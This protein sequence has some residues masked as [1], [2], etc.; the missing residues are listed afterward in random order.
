MLNVKISTEIINNNYF[1]EVKILNK[2]VH[3][4]ISRGVD[5]HTAQSLF[6][7]EEFSIEELQKN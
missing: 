5:S 4:L 6:D 2:T 3:A 1:L 7:S